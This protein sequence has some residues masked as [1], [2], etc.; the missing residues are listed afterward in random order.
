MK[1]LALDA[2][3]SR[4]KWQLVQENS[5]VS[6]GFLL[7]TDDWA[8]AMPSL[9][10]Q[11]GGVDAAIASVVS[12]GVRLEILQQIFARHSA[13]FYVAAVEAEP[14][15]GLYKGLGVDRWLAMLGALHHYQA[16]QSVCDENDNVLIDSD[17]KLLVVDCGTAITID[18]LSAQG[19]YQGGYILPG[20]TMMRNALG[21]GAADLA[22]MRG[23]IDSVKAGHSTKACINHG[24]LAMTV[25]MITTQ[26][27]RYPDSRLYLTGGDAEMI[28]AQ[29]EGASVTVLDLVMGGLVAVFSQK[30]VSRTEYSA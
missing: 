27:N 3:N 21:S 1:L 25:A 18:W 28:R 14:I 8:V 10:T 5:V 2:G 11:L 17:D 6:S 20:I 30:P 22:N 15:K 13:L 23:I 19:V 24:V 9:L 4:L 26:L 16:Q 12:G 7:N 29:L